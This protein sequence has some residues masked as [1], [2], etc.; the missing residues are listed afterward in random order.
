M[1]K[2]WSYLAVALLS[3]SVALAQDPDAEIRFTAGVRLLRDGFPDRALGEI[4][5]A[6]KKDPKNAFY[7][8]GLGLAYSQLAD[9]CKPSDSGCRNEYLKKA[10]DAAQRA[11]VANPDYVDVRNDLGIALLRLG[12]RTDGKAELAKVFADPQGPTPEVTALNLGLA[13]M[14]EKEYTEAVTWFQAAQTKNKAFAAAYVNLSDALLALNQQD[15]AIAQ[16]EIGLKET[17]GNA[18][19]H[20]TLGETYA[21]AGRFQDARAAFEQVVKKDPTG[22]TGRAAAERLRSLAR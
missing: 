5:D 6:L 14:E 11:L 12:K 4:Q 22:A 21:R 8:K 7:L 3:A 20:L 13:F 17:Q 10:V 1:P 2:R 18:I 16:L 15:S 9:K 19:V